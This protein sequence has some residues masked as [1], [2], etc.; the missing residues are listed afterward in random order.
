MPTTVF[1]EQEFMGSRVQES[2]HP[3]PVGLTF[4]YR[5][6]TDFPKRSSIAFLACEFKIFVE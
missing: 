3:D 6:S 2:S 4:R 1:Q 5:N